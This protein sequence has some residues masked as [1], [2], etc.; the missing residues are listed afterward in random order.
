MNLRQFKLGKRP[1]RKR[2]N[3]RKLKRLKKHLKSKKIWK[4]KWLQWDLVNTNLNTGKTQLFSMKCTWITSIDFSKIAGIQILKV[5]QFQRDHT[6]N[7]ALSVAIINHLFL[8]H[9]LT[10]LIVMKTQNKTIIAPMLAVTTRKRW[11]KWVALTNKWSIFL[12]VN[13]RNLK[14]IWFSNM[15]FNSSKKVSE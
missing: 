1:L 15:G 4:I 6:L 5:M 11:K 3:R 7:R 10:T 9:Q 8:N 14:S 12:H 13:S 2:K